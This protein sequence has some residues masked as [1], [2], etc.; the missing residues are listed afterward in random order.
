MYNEP[1][2]DQPEY[3]NTT[4]TLT[5]DDIKNAFRDFYKNDVLGPQQ[6]AYQQNL[7]EYNSIRN[8]PRYKMAGRVFEQHIKNPNVQ[9][10]LNSGQT[11][12]KDEYN[13]TVIAIL[14]NLSGQNAKSKMQQ[15]T[16][17]AAEPEQSVPHMETSESAHVPK[18]DTE[19]EKKEKVKTLTKPENWDGTTDSLRKLVDTM[20]P[21]DDP[22][23][24]R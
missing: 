11:S 14:E 4:G 7:A 6:Q 17:P 10:A 19:S 1:R 24:R 5:K 21:P 18:P 15:V 13:R 3:V 2:Y 20:I 23:W 9:M 8:D 12:L 22:L 16:T